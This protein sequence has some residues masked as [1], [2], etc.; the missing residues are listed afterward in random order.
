MPPEA[1]AR[2][3]SFRRERSQIFERERVAKVAVV[4]EDI[5]EWLGGG[6]GRGVFL[7][8]GE[9]GI[10]QWC[11]LFHVVSFLRMTH[12]DGLCAPPLSLPYSVSGRLFAIRGR[13]EIG[14]PQPDLLDL[15]VLQ[16]LGKFGLRDEAAGA[17]ALAAVHPA[18]DPGAMLA[19][20]FRHGV[21][22][23]E[24][25]DHG[26]CG[27]EVLG[28]HH[29]I[30]AMVALLS[31][32]TF[33]K[34]LLRESQ[35]YVHMVHINANRSDGPGDEESYTPSKRG[36][37]FANQEERRQ[38]RPARWNTWIN[39]DFKQPNKSTS[40]HP[41]TSANGF[42]RGLKPRGRTTALAKLLGIS[43]DKVSKMRMGLRGPQPGELRIIEAFWASPPRST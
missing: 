17:A 35:Y 37:Q 4:L 38:K 28:G 21:D 24:A 29:R 2:G 8:E 40:R 19:A 5:G 31:T 15:G 39:S 22:A 1:P 9:G 16:Q 23:A 13:H 14:G 3:C 10:T 6:F 32:R 12:G 25:L 20:D 33:D 30:V 26:F 36:C 41:Q 42:D 7:E 27:V 18:E 34:S 11:R 43:P